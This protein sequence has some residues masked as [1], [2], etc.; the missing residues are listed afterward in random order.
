MRVLVLAFFGLT[1]VPSTVSASEL[2]IGAAR[3]DI[4]PT[5]PIA[6]SGQFHLRIAKTAETP[7]IASVLV[8]E[9]R[10]GDRPLDCAVFAAFDLVSIP[11]E[12]YDLVRKETQKRIPGLDVSKLI[13]GGTHTHTAPVLNDEW[14]VIPKDGVIQVEEYRK[15]LAARVADAIAQAWNNRKPGSVTW[16]LSHAVVGYNRRASYANG[17]AQMYGRTDVAEFRSLE[18]YED[19]DI[20]TLFC[21]NKE[22][23]LLAVAVNL[24]CT[25]QEVEGRT[26]INADFW[27]PTRQL[28][29]KRFGPDVC[30][31]GLCGAAGDQ[32]PHLM[33][34]KAADE[35]MARLRGLDRMAEIAR[36]IDRAVEEAYEAV[37]DDRHAGIALVH[38]VE[39]LRLPMRLVTEAEYADAKHEYDLVTA[40]LAKDPKLVDQ[41]HGRQA[42]FGNTVRRFERQKSDPKPMYAAEIHVLRIGDAVLCT[43]PFELFTDYGIRIKA[44][45]KAQ[46]TFVVQLIGGGGYLPT[47]KAIAGGSYSAVVHSGRVGPEGGQQLVE[48]TVELI[49]AMMK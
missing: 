11:L 2:W 30:V 5:G 28:L 7:L 26:E 33:Y 25:A 6:I 32:S 46:Q 44:R 35:R 9:S 10:D 36:R 12:V 47:E 13:L 43:S 22:G 8:L 24:S 18:G 40:Q 21:W 49:N 31:L 34:R 39:T 19:H 42:W 23:K 38:K 4:T 48:R 1:L 3:A 14:Y 15:F 41:L 20:G 16:G 29:A 17:T 27:H 45:S 37:K